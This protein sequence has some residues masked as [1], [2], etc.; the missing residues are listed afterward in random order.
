MPIGDFQG[1]DEA[2]IS[3]VPGLDH[4]ALSDFPTGISGLEG[5]ISRIDGV[6]GT[7]ETD[8]ANTIS[9]SYQAGFAVPCPAEGKLTGF[10]SPMLPRRPMIQPPAPILNWMI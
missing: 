3:D 4:V 6:W 8:R 7:A 2:K 10:E 5:I 9:G 1:W